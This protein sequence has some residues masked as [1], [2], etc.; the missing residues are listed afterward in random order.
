[1]AGGQLRH[2]PSNVVGLAARIDEDA[3]IEMRRTSRREFLGIV[4][5][6]LVQ[7]SG[8]RRQYRCLPGNGAHNRRMAMADVRH[9][10]VHVE[11]LPPLRV[12]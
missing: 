11:I 5:N 12:E 2:A 7:V 1:M 3:G 9:V 8:M 10:V 6:L 4:E